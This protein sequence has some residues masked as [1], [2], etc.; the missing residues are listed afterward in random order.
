M[1]GMDNKTKLL[2]VM[3]LLI[4]AALAA[5]ADNIPFGT[6]LSGTESEIL[7][8]MPR[9]LQ[10]REQPALSSG[11]DMHGPF[12]FSAAESVGGVNPDGAPSLDPG[13]NRRGLSL[14]VTGEGRKLAILEGRLVKEGD[15]I[16]DKRIARIESD[17]IL[18]KDKTMQWKYM[19]KEK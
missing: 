9:E 17:R 15:T 5:A 1:N 6:I 10:I 12:D 8:F 7:S 4:A 16:D 13:T 18:L 14:I 3:P 11:R 2:L 19:E